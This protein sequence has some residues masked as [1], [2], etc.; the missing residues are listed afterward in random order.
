MASLR[1]ASNRAKVNSHSKM[2]ATTKETLPRT[3][4]A[5]MESTCIQMVRSTSVSS[6]TDSAM[7]KESLLT[8]QT[9]A[10]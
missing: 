9:V 4:S 2:A 8:E 3:G 10:K 6:R 1:T 7:V 5:A